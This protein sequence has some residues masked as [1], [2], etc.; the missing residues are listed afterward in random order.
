MNQAVNNNN[1]TLKTCSAKNKSYSR[2][3]WRLVNYWVKIAEAKIEFLEGTHELVESPIEF[4]RRMNRLV[5]LSDDIK[6]A[7]EVSL[8]HA[9]LAYLDFNET[10]DHY[11]TEAY[12][13]KR[14][15]EGDLDD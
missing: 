9:Y 3:D 6:K 12:G 15:L 2:G 4:C 11:A 7:G 14:N 8:K 13:W 1:S 5:K 10:A